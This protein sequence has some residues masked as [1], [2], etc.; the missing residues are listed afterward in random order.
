M[1]LFIA[2][3]VVGY[4]LAGPRVLGGERRQPS[5]SEAVRTGA[6]A[7]L[8]AGAVFAAFVVFV[9]AFG[10]HWVRNVFVNVSPTR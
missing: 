6:L 9:D 2:P 8:A 10:V 4:L 1:R 3:Y 5:R 7:G